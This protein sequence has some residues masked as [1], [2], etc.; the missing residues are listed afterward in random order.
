VRG[1]FAHHG[2]AGLARL[3]DELRA[4]GRPLTL[5]D[6]ACCCPAR[7]AVT[8]IMPPATGRSDPV[9]LLL[10]G[11]HWRAGRDALRAAAATAYDEAGILIMSGGNELPPARREPSAAA[12]ARPGP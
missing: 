11:H 10:C 9:D 7:P 5:A 12:A 8:V 3:D 4:L 2:D 6:H 1:W